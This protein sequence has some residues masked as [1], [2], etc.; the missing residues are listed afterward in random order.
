MKFLIFTFFFLSQAQAFTLNNNFGASFDSHRVKVHVAGDTTCARSGLTVYELDDLIKEA[1]DEFWNRVPT[2][3]LRLIP[4]EPT[5]I[6]NNINDGKLCG[7]TDDACISGSTGNV[8]PPVTGIVIACNTL[9][10]NFG[11]NNVLAVTIPNNFA[12]RRIK[13]AVILINEVSTAFS[14]LSREDKIG[15]IAHEIG[16]AIGLG[17]TEDKAALMYYRTVELRRALGQDDI[18]GVSY[19]Y[20][21]KFDGC[22]AMGTIDDGQKIDPMIGQMIIGFIFMLLFGKLFKRPERSP[23][24]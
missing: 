17:H 5:G 2:S 15:V 4:G 12:G 18:D 8:I 23:T 14:R 7:P 6:I 20:P 21:V 16:H 22:G 9:P 19:L 1:I 10:S 13:G 24:T 11:Q 3:S